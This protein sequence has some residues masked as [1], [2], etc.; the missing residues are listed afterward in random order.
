M[1]VNDTRTRFNVVL[2]RMAR[3][4]PLRGPGESGKKMMLKLVKLVLFLSKTEVSLVLVDTVVF[5]VSELM[6]YQASSSSFIFFRATML[7]KD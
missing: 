2:C 5:T 4:P 6:G 1:I 3:S 7:L